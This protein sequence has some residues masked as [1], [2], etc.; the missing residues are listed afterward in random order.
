[1][2]LQTTFAGQKSTLQHFRGVGGG[3]QVPPQVPPLPMPAD[4]HGPT[5]HIHTGLIVFS[6]QRS[7]ARYLL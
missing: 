5:V 6:S 2:R 4:V 7:E 1:M 3:K